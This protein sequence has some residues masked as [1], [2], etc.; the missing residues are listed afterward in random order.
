M[1]TVEISISGMSVILYEVRDLEVAY[2]LFVTP[3]GAGPPFARLYLMPKSFLGPMYYVSY[4]HCKDR[5][6]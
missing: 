2:I 3:S 4:Q 5:E 6:A 1:P